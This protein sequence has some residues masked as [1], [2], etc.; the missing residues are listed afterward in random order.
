MHEISE[1]EGKSERVRLAMF[2]DDVDEHADNLARQ[3]ANEFYSD[4]D[5][6]FCNRARISLDHL[7]EDMGLCGILPNESIRAEVIGIY[8]KRLKWALA[9]A[10][11]RDIREVKRDGA[12]WYEFYR[13]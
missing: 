8:N 3:I 13:Y 2:M 5:P 12:Y 6:H 10:G 9:D 7:Y 11:F 4:D 1:Y